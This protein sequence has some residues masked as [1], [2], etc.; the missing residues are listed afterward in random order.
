MHFTE[1]DTRLGAYALIVD[2]QRR[3]LL[4]WY[5]GPTPCWT[6]PGGGV[7][8]GESCE[9]A[10]MRE[11]HEETGYQVEVGRVLTVSTRTAERSF[12][13]DLPFQAVRVV[14][15]AQVVGGTLGTLEVG[16][17][18]DRAEWIPIDALDEAGPR[19]DLV[20]DLVATWCAAT[21]PS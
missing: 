11:V 12:Q 13:R 8:F 17:T 19:A 6:L 10:V 5:N 3:I 15:E 14:Y 18:T 2:E 20:S 4:S 1:Y 16:G 9:D 7:D 21:Q